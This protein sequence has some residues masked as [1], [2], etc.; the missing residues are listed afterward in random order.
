MTSRNPSVRKSDLSDK[1]ERYQ[2]LRIACSNDIA[3]SIANFLMEKT[4]AG[5][6]VENQS[7]GNQQFFTAYL[8][9]EIGQTLSAQEIE[10]YFKSIRVFFADPHMEILGIDYIPAE[11]W[12]AG[13]KK[14]FVPIHVAGNIVVRPTWESYQVQPGEIEIII[15]PKMAFGTGHHETTAQC[16][17][18]L[19]T[20][21]LRGRTLLDYGCGTGILSIA[22]AK[23]GAA[24]VIAVDN[25]EEAIACAAENFKLNKI[26]AELI[27]ADRFVAEPA[28]DII[29]ANL[30]VD[31]I[32]AMARE[33]R[34]SLKKNGQ[35][36]FSGI[37]L[38]NRD[39]FED[40]L[41]AKKYEVISEIRGSEWVSFVGVK[42]D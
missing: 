37:P 21:N 20:I 5:L 13:W 40:F 3:E 24:R 11:D 38:E 36:I 23:L 9:S 26:D 14:T 8:R 35:I 18:A 12:L 34:Q 1:S 19:K 41:A 7:S 2:R 42:D 22:G 25:D 29:V 16:L 32:L 27:K 17:E 4:A 15:D 10:K 31:Q 30:T 33:L 28:C 6:L 39:R